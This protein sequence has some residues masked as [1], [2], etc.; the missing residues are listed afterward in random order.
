M[1]INKW[2]KH[3]LLYE[4]DDWHSILQKKIFRFITAG[5]EPWPPCSWCENYTDMTTDQE[6]GGLGSIPVV[7]NLFE[8]KSKNF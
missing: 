6:R 8:E 5:I 1:T 4:E 7:A 3:K 2:V